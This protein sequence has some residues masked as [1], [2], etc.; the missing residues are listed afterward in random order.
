MVLPYRARPGNSHPEESLSQERH[1]MNEPRRNRSLDLHSQVPS[2]FTAR[3]F[4][5]HS[6][7]ILPRKA[8]N[9]G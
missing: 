3:P 4:N 7:M 2:S 8:N 1:A 9:L 6:V 5:R